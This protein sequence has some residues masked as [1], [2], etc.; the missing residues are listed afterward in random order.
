MNNK[1]HL[2]I[3]FYLDGSF[4]VNTVAD[5]DLKDNIEYNRVFRFGRFYFVDGEYT[6][7]GVLKEPYQSEFIEQCKQ[8]IEELNIQPDNVPSIPYQ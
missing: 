5:E 2:C 4:K 8:R 6:C 3:G 7:G 1:L